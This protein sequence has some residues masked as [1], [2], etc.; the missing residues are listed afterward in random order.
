M[1]IFNISDDSQTFGENGQKQQQVDNSN[2]PKVVDL[3]SPV[4]DTKEV[5]A[6]TDPKE[7]LANK[8][9][10]IDGPLSNIYT[11]ALNMVYSKENIVNMI[12]DPESL[13]PESK[14]ESDVYLYCC[15]GDDV[16]TQNGLIRT[17]D[18]IFVAAEQHKGKQI[19]LAVE[20]HGVITERIAL[21][22]GYAESLGIKFMSNRSS[23]VE[24]V[25]NNLK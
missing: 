19:I 10:V 18:A 15:D 7:Q 20:C 25:K 6:G 3:D 24:A 14:K 21:L 13:D 22:H 8:T 16:G 11:Q 2:H 4:G 12:Q 1:G 5:S 17:T 23:A 9:I